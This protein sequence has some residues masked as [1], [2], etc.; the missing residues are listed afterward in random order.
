MNWPLD[1]TWQFVEIDYGIRWLK[2][3]P[4][5]KQLLNVGITK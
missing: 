2:E 4:T 3:K 1:Q 5:G